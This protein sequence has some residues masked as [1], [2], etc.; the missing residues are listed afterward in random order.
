MH[1]EGFI[2]C[3]HIP[4][5]CFSPPQILSGCSSSPTQW[6]SS[7]LPLDG[8]FLFFSRSLGDPAPPW[9][10]GKPC[11][12]VLHTNLCRLWYGHETQP[13]KT[14]LEEM[15]AK[16]FWEHVTLWSRPVGTYYSLLWRQSPQSHLSLLE[17]RAHVKN[18]ADEA[19]QPLSSGQS[20]TDWNIRLWNVMCLRRRCHLALW[21]S[22]LEFSALRCLDSSLNSDK[23]CCFLVFTQHGS[24]EPT[25]HPL[26]KWQCS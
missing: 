19:G 26:Q 8:S 1:G 23:E 22:V 14:G 24:W 21:S 12:C 13:R 25:L 20:Y 17:H 9:I 2:F 15:S 4:P 16:G 10:S 6:Q 7:R 5:L 3:P 11:I 18:A